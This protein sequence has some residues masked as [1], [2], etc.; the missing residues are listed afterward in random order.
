MSQQRTRDDSVP[1]ETVTTT[2]TCE[3]SFTCD[4]L[5]CRLSQERSCAQALT[6]DS[7]SRLHTR[8]HTFAACVLT[9][10]ASSPTSA[11]H[12]H[13]RASMHALLHTHAVVAPYYS[14]FIPR[15]ILLK[16]NLAGT[17]LGSIGYYIILLLI[18]IN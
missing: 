1:V 6:D 4:E 13:Q 2:W 15:S 11:C 9:C 12:T 7:N 18:I 3:M 8:T 14:H 17:R 16:E 10:Y 5:C